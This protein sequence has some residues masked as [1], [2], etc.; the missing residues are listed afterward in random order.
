MNLIDLEILIP[1][2]PEFIWRF[3][4]DLQQIPRWQKGAE[5]ITFLSTQH[6]GR[7]TR[8]RQSMSS[9]PDRVVEVSAWY[10]TLGYTYK[11]VAGVAYGENQGQIKLREVPEGTL[12][13]WTFQYEPGGVLGGLRNAVGLKGSISSQIQASLRNLH[14]LISQQSGGI[15]THE[16]KATMQEAPDASARSSY[17][18]RHP[19]SYQES[20]RGDSSTDAFSLAGEENPFAFDYAMVPIPASEDGDTKPNPVALAGLSSFSDE[21]RLEDDTQPMDVAVPI[22]D[23]RPIPADDAPREPA[24]EAPMP[25]QPPRRKDID[26]ANMSV[27]E[28]FGLQ[29]PSKAIL[30]AEPPAQSKDD[31]DTPSSDEGQPPATENIAAP[32]PESGSTSKWRANTGARRAERRR[33][34]LMRSK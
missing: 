12:V 32:Q 18:P 8:W 31:D 5:T 22:P 1:A 17:E 13:R 4:G 16:A 20:Q 23:S 10:E 27:F 26:T 33:A 30:A 15:S 29:K 11:V 7:G 9:G 3:L 19:S 28:V 25:A 2:S 6:E 24:P 21:L 34:I 14:Q